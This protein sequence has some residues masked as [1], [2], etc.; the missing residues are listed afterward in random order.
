MR[1]PS[2]PFALSGV[3]QEGG[4]EDYFGDIITTKESNTLRIGFQN[5]GGFLIKKDKLKNDVIRMGLTQ[6]DFDIFGFS[7]TNIDWRLASE[8]DKLYLRC[9]EWW[10]TVHISYSNNTTSA[11]I[12][13]HQYGG[14]ALFSLNK[15]SHRVISKGQ[16]ES[17]LGRWVWTRCRG[18]NNHTLRIITGYRPNPPSGGPFTVYSQHRLYFNS[19]LDHICPRT[20]FVQDLCKEIEIFKAEGDHIILILD[21]NADIRVGELQVSLENCHLRE[22]LLERHGVN[23]PSTYRRNHQNIPIDGIW[24]S[25]GI[26]LL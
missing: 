23:C 16:D 12:Q 19:I 24:A 9:K 26:Q 6:W 4:N 18:R 25:P 3:S 2:A 21:G 17:Q 15:A 22:V 11:P 14:T 7:E 20:A 1:R 5:I 13:P 10:D 8:E